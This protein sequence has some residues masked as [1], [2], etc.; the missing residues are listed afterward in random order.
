MCGGGAS[1]ALSV[2]LC[3]RRLLRPKNGGKAKIGTGEKPPLTF[4]ITTS[5][6]LKLSS[7]SDAA[8]RL[9]T[10]ERR[11]FWRNAARE[12]AADD[13]GADEGSDE[14]ESEG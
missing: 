7:L 9:L 4:S 10:A 2:G 6:A 8:F 5:A 3:R 12:A 1:L 11:K 13:E 14:G